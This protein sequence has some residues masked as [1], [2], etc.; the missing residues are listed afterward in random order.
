MRTFISRSAVH[1]LLSTSTL[2]D[3][4]RIADAARASTTAISN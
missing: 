1:A 3:G 4:A 2:A